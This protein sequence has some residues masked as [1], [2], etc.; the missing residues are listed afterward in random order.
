V[1]VR[2]ERRGNR[3]TIEDKDRVWTKDKRG[4]MVIANQ[5]IVG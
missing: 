4:L 1:L 3:A 2:I 5:E